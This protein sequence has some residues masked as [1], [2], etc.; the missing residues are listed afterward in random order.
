MAVFFNADEVFEI[1]VNIELNGERFYKASAGLTSEPKVKKLF[2]FLIM[3]EQIHRKTF[4]DMR[5]D[6]PTKF[7]LPVT[8]DPAGEAAAYLKALADSHIFNNPE[9]KKKVAAGISD[10]SPALDFAL[11][12]EK[13]S[14]LFYDQMKAI[15]SSELGKN[16][17]DSI[18]NEEKKH[19]LLLLDMKR[20]IRRGGKK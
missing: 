8:F 4:E 12:F 11:S 1:A 3:Q 5:K 19:I 15:T 10:L 9:G 7:T 17:I 2:E 16:Q 6:L 20:T 14:V 13:D 18:I